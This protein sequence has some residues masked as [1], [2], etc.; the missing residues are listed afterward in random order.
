MTRV[1]EIASWHNWYLHAIWA[2]YEGEYLNVIQYN[3]SQIDPHIKAFR[4]NNPR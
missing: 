2:Q 3:F 1:S 4:L